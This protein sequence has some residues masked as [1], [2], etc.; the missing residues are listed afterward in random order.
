MHI[1]HV[2][3]VMKNTILQFEM[4]IFVY[5]N[6]INKQIKEI[7][8]KISEVSSKQFLCVASGINFAMILSM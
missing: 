7:G 5:G 6:K 2:G 8:V 4:K 1:M 3:Y